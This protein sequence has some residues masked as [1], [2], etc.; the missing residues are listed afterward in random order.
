MLAFIRG[1]WWI[2]KVKIWKKDLMILPKIWTK[3]CKTT[4][5]LF[6]QLISARATFFSSSFFFFFKIQF[7]IYF[8]YYWPKG[9]P[10]PI[11][12]NINYIRLY[13]KTA[14]G[15]DIGPWVVHQQEYA[16][17]WKCGFSCLGT[18]RGPILILKAV[19]W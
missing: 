9:P 7:E 19:F 2:T 15:I 14:F 5:G 16:R 6:P 18:S 13:K 17:K 12:W 4:N 1:V 11:F 3:N 8:L 10:P